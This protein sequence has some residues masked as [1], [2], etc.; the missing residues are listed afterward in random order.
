MSLLAVGVSHQ[1]APVALLEQFAMGADD[2]VKALHELVGSDH[3]SEALV[4]ATCN[5][6]EVF[7]EV[8]RFHGGVTD[9]SRV[10]ARQAGAT[11]EELSPY[12][13]VHYEDQAV[14]HLFT[15]AAGLDSMVVGETQV[16][17]QLR[18]AYALAREEGT[19]GRALHP[20]AQR[21]LR[22]GKRVHSET[23]IDRAGASLV[24]VALDRAE[25]RI[26][27]LAGRPVLVVGA[28]SMGALAATTL[29]RR[30]ADVVVSSRTP[31]S[32]GRLAE[33]VG[34]RAAPL[35]RMGGEI[36]AADVLVTC[37][38]ATGLVVGTDVV[39]PAMT[40]RR[41]RPLV[42][43]DLALPRDVDPGVAALPGVHVVD[44]ALLQGE[45]HDGLATAGPVAADDI[46]AARAMIEA[47]AALL[48]AERQAAEVG[49][50][51]S[52]LRSQAAEVVD[53]ELLRLAGRLPD[54]D[55]R[56]RAEISRTVR[57]VVDKLLHEPTVRVKELAATPGGTDYAGALRALFGL[58]I[59][60]DVTPGA[61]RLADAVTVDP[62]RPGGPA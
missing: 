56:A 49:P 58:G 53:A 5:R 25:A 39:A 42:V 16:L 52:A 40:G 4:L 61:G 32:A 1:T 54:L 2:R 50:T 51:V 3:V 18:A 8:E 57:R 31:A 62:D 12:V 26:G 23:G 43:I 22:V 6:V 15:V 48:R 29:A 44:L 7:A 37:T 21:A 19:V 13:T 55:A 41:D 11:V 20:V 45:R 38:G 28:G 34:G 60:A 36:A 46:S 30:G 9:V 33:A 35:S 27:A 24:S 47:E 14:A 10:L 59:D 17:G